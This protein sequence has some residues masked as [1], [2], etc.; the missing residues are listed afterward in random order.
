[1]GLQCHRVGRINYNIHRKVRLCFIEKV[2]FE[3]ILER[4]K[5]VSYVDN[6]VHCSKQG[7]LLSQNPNPGECLACL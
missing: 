1:M 3:H 5:R 7:E 6:C 4:N 2:I